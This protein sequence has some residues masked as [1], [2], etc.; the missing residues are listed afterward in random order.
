MGQHPQAEKETGNIKE[1]KNEKHE[2]LY[3]RDTGHSKPL[4]R[5]FSPSSAGPEVSKTQ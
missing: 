2:D 1:G 5:L 4:C 3:E